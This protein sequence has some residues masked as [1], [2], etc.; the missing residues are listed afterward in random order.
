MK[1]KTNREV[2]FWVENK[3]DDYLAL[4]FDE[5]GNCVRYDSN[6]DRN[7]TVENW[8]FFHE[9]LGKILKAYEKESKSWKD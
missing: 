2:R 3:D 8:Q 1:I 7:K 6:L 9:A 5:Q 4:T